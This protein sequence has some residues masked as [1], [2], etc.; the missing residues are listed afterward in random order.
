[1]SGDGG[2][3][4]KLGDDGGMVV[5]IMLVD[6]WLMGVRAAGQLRG[7]V[8]GLCAKRAVSTMGQLGGWPLQRAGSHVG[9]GKGLAGK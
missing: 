5:G 9:N 3:C 7:R 4:A 6:G 1:M 8:G 2:G